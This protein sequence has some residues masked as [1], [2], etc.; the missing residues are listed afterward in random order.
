[1]TPETHFAQNGSVNIAY[2][3][4]GDGPS[5]IVIIPGWLSNLDLFWEE[6]MAARFFLALARFSRVILID[7]RG[8]GLSDR[9]PPPTLEVQMDDVKAVMDAT[10]SERAALLGYSEGG[11]MC[12]L[13]AATYP[14][15]TTSLILIGSYARALASDDYPFGSTQEESEEWLT[16]IEEEW[17]GPIA[18]DEIV[19]TLADNERFRRWLAKYFRS[20]VSKTDAAAMHRMS[21]E[22]DI[23]PI[24][25]SIRVRTLVLH[26]KGDRVCPLEGGRYI[27]RRI[28][29]TKLVELDTEDHLPYVGCPNEIVHEIQRFIGNEPKAHVTN[30][31]LTTV[32]FTDIVDSTQLAASLGDVPWHDL[33]EGHHDAVRRALEI[34]R[35]HEVKTTGDGFHATFDGPARAVQ[36]AFAIRESTRE[37]GLTLRMGI[38]TGECE[39]RGESMEG[40]A[41]HFAARVSA[42]AR[43][44]EILVSRTVKDLIAGS[45][46]EL[47]DFGTHALRG[48]PDEY[49]LFKAIAA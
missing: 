23:R 6:P 33:L 35:G 17:G 1:M 18:I 41:I 2:Q 45:G 19:P 29:N 49:Q 12:M 5:D 43:G 8:T 16:M 22:I 20:S 40:L 21:M 46:I 42:M 36:C 34:F 13:F 9:V 47:E 14:D 44:G 28:P 48:I 26:A 11:S 27:A 32:L 31:V 30:R 4:F 10:N 25:E 3:A 7:K 24:L 39:I 15:R 38:H 37:L